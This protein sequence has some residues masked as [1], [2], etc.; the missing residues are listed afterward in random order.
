MGASLAIPREVIRN[1]LLL[2]TLGFVRH[3]QHIN[4]ISLRDWNPIRPKWL[5]ERGRRGVTRGRSKDRIVEPCAAD[6]GIALLD[7]AGHGHI[8]SAGGYRGHDDFD[9]VNVREGWV[10]DK[11]IEEAST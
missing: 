8:G 6:S 9:A 10:A 1:D 4:E 7:C 3:P 11:L 2:D 5:R